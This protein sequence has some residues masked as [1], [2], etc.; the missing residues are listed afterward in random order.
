MTYYV[1]KDKKGEKVR[2]GKIVCLARSYRRHA[3]EMHTNVTEEP[4]L[5]LKPASSVIFDG[6]SIIIPKMSKCLHHEVEMG[7]VIGKK[8]KEVPQKNALDYVLGYLVCLDI[9]ARDIQ[10]KAKKNSWPWTIAK[11]FDTFAPISDVVLKDKIKNPNNLDLSL[12]VNGKVRQKSNTKYMI[13]SVERIIE[14]VSGI[15]TLEKGDLIM[16]GT[17]EGVGEI[18]AGDVLEA[19]FGDFC[20]LKVDVR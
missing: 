10:D 8:C 3:E 13:Y 2:V 11:G 15:M 17:P 4:L 5:F 7:I 9:T 19:K 20:F 16:T 14:F 6:D 1:F 18:A 12:K